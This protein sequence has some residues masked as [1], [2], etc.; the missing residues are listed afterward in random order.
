VKKTQFDLE[1]QERLRFLRRFST[2]ILWAENSDGVE[3]SQTL[4]YYRFISKHRVAGGRLVV[5]G[6][7]EPST[8][9][10]NY[11]AYLVY[12]QRLHRD[13]MYLELEPGV[14]FPRTRDFQAT[15]LVSLKLDILMGD[16]EPAA[17]AQP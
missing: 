9:M 1:Q 12:R 16:W 8:R 4:A 2:V 17:T 7:L 3:A 5:S 14:E 11:G 10:E 13:W 15:G 6:V